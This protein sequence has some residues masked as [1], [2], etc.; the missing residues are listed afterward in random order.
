MVSATTLEAQINLTTSIIADILPIRPGLVTIG[1]T[2]VPPGVMQPISTSPE[3]TLRDIYTLLANHFDQRVTEGGYG[4]FLEAI[5]EISVAKEEACRNAS[6][7][8]SE[9]LQLI[10]EFVTAYKMKD[11][12]ILSVYGKLLCLNSTINSNSSRKRRASDGDECE[13]PPDGFDSDFTFCHFCDFY[14]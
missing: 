7:I 10:Q 13:C 8:V 3:S 1:V 12:K 14:A 5:N 6:G 2:V 11:Q 4:Q 9:S